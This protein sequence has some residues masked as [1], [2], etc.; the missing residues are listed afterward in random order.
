[1]KNTIFCRYNK[2]V[3]QDKTYTSALYAIYG[4]IF[5]FAW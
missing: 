5:V 4:K 2:T 1:M 3:L